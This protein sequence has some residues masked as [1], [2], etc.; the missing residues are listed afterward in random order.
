M[1]ETLINGAVVSLKEDIKEIKGELRIIVEILGSQR[2]QAKQIETIEK[3]LIELNKMVV[4]VPAF[5][6]KILT[7][8]KEIL[9]IKSNLT[10]IYFSIFG[11]IITI[12]ASFFK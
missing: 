7:N 1:T 10:K 5:N 2:V 4:T 6:E 12:A 3:G 9:N 11:T 8:E